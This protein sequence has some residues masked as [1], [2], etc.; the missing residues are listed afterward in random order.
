MSVPE[1]FISMED[2]GLTYSIREKVDVAEIQ[3]FILVGSGT[4]SGHL[5]VV[6]MDT[7]RLLIELSLN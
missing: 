5:L 1:H 4:S 6:Y 7:Q 2:F 3:V